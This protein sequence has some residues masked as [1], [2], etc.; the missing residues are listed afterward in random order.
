VDW[1]LIQAIARTLP[2]G[3]AVVPDNAE[4]SDY[5]YTLAAAALCRV[6][7]DAPVDDLADLLEK[8]IEKGRSL[9]AIAKFASTELLPGQWHVTQLASLLAVEPDPLKRWEALWRVATPLRERSIHRH[10]HDDS[11]LIY[12]GPFMLALGLRLYDL[13]FDKDPGAARLL[14]VQLYRATLETYLVDRLLRE[15]LDNL[16][17]HGFVRAPFMAA[18]GPQ[19]LDGSVTLTDS[20][21]PYLTPNALAARILLLLRRGGIDATALAQACALAG[22]DISHLS[23]E[24]EELHGLGAIRGLST[25]SLASLQALVQAADEW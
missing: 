12:V 14:W 22:R 20:L 4:N 21:A 18:Y 13:L 2:A 15:R 1:L 17:L 8:F 10:V 25:E 23:A 11:D 19:D 16:I 5:L 3:D 24:I 6:E 9:P 7:H